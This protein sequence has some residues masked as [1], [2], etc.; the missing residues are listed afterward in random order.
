MQSPARLFNRFRAAATKGRLHRSLSWRASENPLKDHTKYNQDLEIHGRPSKKSL[1]V[2]G[3]Q[4]A[5]C[6]KA[7]L[8]AG[9]F[10]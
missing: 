7:W 10:E 5:G 9:P 6:L 3:A 8:S 2:G 4:L 1:L